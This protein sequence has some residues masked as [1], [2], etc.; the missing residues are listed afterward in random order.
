[1]LGVLV[2]RSN[3]SRDLPELDEVSVN[4]GTEVESV[5]YESNR[6]FSLE[7]TSLEVINGIIVIPFGQKCWA[8]Y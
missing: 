1:V 8:Q 4:V 7:M 2:L 3:G 5:V 6:W